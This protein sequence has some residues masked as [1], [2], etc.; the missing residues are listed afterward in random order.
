MRS[1]VLAIILVG[2]FWNIGYDGS[3]N[4]IREWWNIDAFIGNYSITASFEYEKET[5]AANLFLTIFDLN[6]NIVYNLSSYNDEINVFKRG[7]YEVNL[8]YRDSWMRGAYPYYRVHFENKGIIIDM[9]I[10]AIG[11]PVFVAGD[12]L[13]IGM[14]YC[15]Y[16][17]IPKCKVNGEIFINNETEK[18]EG[19]GYFEHVWGN[20]SYNKPLKKEGK[21]IGAYIKL[22]RKWLNNTEISFDKICISS[23]NPFGYDWCWAVFENGYTMFYGAIPFWLDIPFGIIYFY[24]GKNIVEEFVDYEYLNGTIYENAYIPT[25]IRVVGKNISFI[26]EMRNKPHIYKDN[27]SSF[28]WKKLILY[29]CPGDI[30]GFYKGEEIKGK[31]EIEIER[32]TSIFGYILLKIEWNNGLEITIIFPKLEI[33]FHIPTFII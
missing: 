7:K 20:W 18:F 21:V 8:S 2:S 25:K 12:I 22:I 23:D 28:Y 24:D 14:G 16:L 17:F 27:L 33:R 15:K 30:Y 10:R 32:Q 3:H 6:R 11:P 4:C 1:V 26:M 31:C 29:E 9:N 5:P 19:I 13:P